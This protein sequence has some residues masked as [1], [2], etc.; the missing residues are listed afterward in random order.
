M[1][2]DVRYTIRLRGPLN[3]YIVREAEK[4]NILPVAMIK[5]ILAEYEEEK[6]NGR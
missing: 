2:K 5:C 1:E 3:E 6:R 4:R